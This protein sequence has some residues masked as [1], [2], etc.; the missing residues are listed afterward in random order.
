MPLERWWEWEGFGAT[1]GGCL[2]GMVLAAVAIGVGVCSC[3]GSW[4][5][6]T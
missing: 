4:G 1:N 2:E 5:E 6:A 3:K